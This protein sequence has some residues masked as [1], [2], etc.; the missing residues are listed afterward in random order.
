MTLPQDPNKFYAG[1]RYEALAQQCPRCQAGTGN[2]CVD[3]KI[4]LIP[5]YGL[6]YGKRPPQETERVRI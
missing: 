2:L 3:C 1:H 5:Y 4:V 6:Y